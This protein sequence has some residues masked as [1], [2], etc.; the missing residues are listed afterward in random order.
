MRSAA[1]TTRRS[2]LPA[3]PPDTA[4]PVVFH[5]ER[6]VSSVHGAGAYLFLV[7]FRR[8]PLERTAGCEF[9]HLYHPQVT[10][11]KYFCLDSRHKRGLN[12]LNLRNLRT[13]HYPHAS[14]FFYSH[15][16]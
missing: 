16:A 1:P 6:L 9:S 13:F 4:T 15:L 7:Q 5:P 12:L 3:S 2:T 8:F 14:P 11:I 10:Q